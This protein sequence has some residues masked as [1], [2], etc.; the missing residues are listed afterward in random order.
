MIHLPSRPE[1]QNIDQWNNF[2][3]R[4]RVRGPFGGTTVN[5]IKK[6]NS[7]LSETDPNRSNSKKTG[8]VDIDVVQ[9]R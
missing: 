7:H 3:R 1:R 8:V 2:Y 9:H 5:G 4:R 6:Q